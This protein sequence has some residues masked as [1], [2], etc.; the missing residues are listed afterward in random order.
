MKLPQIAVLALAVVG[1]ILEYLNQKTFGIHGVWHS[2]ITYGIFIVGSLGVTAAV[3]H[4]LGVDIEELFHL[5]PAAI[6]FI[7][8]GAVVLAGAVQTFSIGGIWKGLV[9]GA[10]SFVLTVFGPAL[11]IKHPPPPAPAAPTA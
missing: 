8:T 9:L 7:T 2:V 11:D 3:G 10:S 6:A 4:Q 5:S 1:G